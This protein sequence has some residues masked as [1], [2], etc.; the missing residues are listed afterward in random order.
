M[1]S[2]KFNHDWT[3]STEQESALKDY[4]LSAKMITDIGAG[5]LELSKKCIKLGAEIVY[6]VDYEF[7]QKDLKNYNIVKV[8]HDLSSGLPIINRDKYLNA[9]I[10]WPQG[11]LDFDTLSEYG[12]QHINHPNWLKILPE[13]K[14]VLY[15]GKNCDGHTSGLPIFWAILAGWECRYLIPDKANNMVLY[16]NQKRIKEHPLN[17]EEFYAFSGGNLEYKPNTEVSFGKYNDEM[18]QILAGWRKSVGLQ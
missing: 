7:P 17:I 1:Y 10:S 5:D 4:C 11:E 12:M 14:S 6:A 9:I 2:N 8:K 18:K 16:T 3:L 13:L 15:L